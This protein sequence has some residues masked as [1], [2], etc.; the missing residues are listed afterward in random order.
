LLAEMVRA[1][2]RAGEPSS[3]LD[4]FLQENHAW[5]ALCHWLDLDAGSARLPTKD[6]VGRRL[7]H[8]I[9]RIDQLLE[10]QVNAI[11]HHESFQRL[12]ASWRGLRFLFDALPEDDLVKIRVLDVSWKELELDLTNALE[13][14]QSQLFKKVYENE[15]GMPGG[16]PFGVL[17]GDYEI[18]HRRT[19]EHPQDDIEILGKLAE[20]AA[21]AFAPFIA[22]VHPSFFGLDSFTELERPLDLPRTFEQLEY[23]RWR[24]LRQREDSRFVG[25]TL[26]RILMR[27]PYGRRD[28]RSQGLR[29]EEAPGGPDNR[30]YVWG[31]AVYAF[32]SVLIRAFAN[33]GWPAD[34]RGVRHSLDS[35]GNGV[36]LEEAGVVTGLPVESFH[37]D[38]VGIATKSS[39]DVIITDSQEKLFGELGFIPLCHC[40]DTEYSAFYGNQSIQQPAKYDDPKATHNAR[41]SAMLQ[42][43]LC[44]SRFA[45]YIKVLARDQI[46]SMRG[47]HECEEFLNRWLR[48]YTNANESAGPEVK[49]RRPLHEASVRVVENLGNPGSYSCVIH[50]RPH[51]Q[52]EQLVSSLR[53]AT[54]LAPARPRS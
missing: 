51:Y 39:T 11:L 8:D 40:Y 4:R 10:T 9:A 18:H 2:G 19:P 31:N 45:H 30:R 28:A 35:N 41:L 53:F 20:V 32:G 33:L 1:T 15:F 36:F 17:L 50:L 27:L 7:V 21:A 13:F 46:G 23:L 22:G 42:Y 38:G 12:E 43:I 24:S 16:Q 48:E 6:E 54:E 14:D 47:P 49:A 34:I 5:R 29:F 37:T 52:V 3:R 44:V 25:L 26:P